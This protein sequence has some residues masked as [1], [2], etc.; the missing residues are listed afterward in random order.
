MHRFALLVLSLV[1]LCGFAPAQTLA[2]CSPADTLVYFR[3]WSGD[4]MEALKK[5]MGG[6]GLWEQPVDIDQIFEMMDE[7]MSQMSDF[8]G[9]EGVN[10]GSMVRS[11]KGYEGALYRLDLLDGFPEVDFVFTLHT[12]MADKIYGLLSGK[13][14]EEAMAD[15]VSKDEVEVNVDEFSMNIGKYDDQIIIASSSNRLRETMKHFGSVKAGSLAQSERFKKAVGSSD[16]PDYCIYISAQPFL[17]ML[18]E[19]MDFGGQRMGMMEEAIRSFGLFKIDALGWTERENYSHFALSAKSNIEVLEILDCGRG[20]HGSLDTMPS[21]T[22]IGMTWNGSTEALWQKGSAFA[23]D[24][25]KNPMAPYVEEGLRSAQ[26][27]MGLKIGEIAA[28]GKGGLSFGMMPN[29][30]GQ[31]DDDPSNFFFIVHTGGIETARDTV[32]KLATVLTKR[33]GGE[34]TIEEDGDAIWYHLARD[35]EDTDPPEV[36]SP[37]SFRVEFDLPS[38]VFTGNDIIIAVK[39][40]AQKVMAARSGAIPTLA[41]YN[42]CKG[43]PQQASAYVFVSL[44]TILGSVGNFAAAYHNMRDGAGIAAAI[45]IQPNRFAVRTSRPVSQIWG[46]MG[47]AAMA[48]EGQKKGRRAI[49][50]DL[51]KIAKKYREYRGEHQKDPTTLA[52]LGFTGENALRYPPNRPANVPGKPYRLVKTEGANLASSRR[53]VVV[54]CPDPRYGRLVGTL[55]GKSSDWSEQRFQ[56]TFRRQAYPK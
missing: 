7:G 45:D 24:K 28:I 49:L 14:V 36:D 52:Q 43:L 20:G 30:D 37:R 1:L 23:L 17:Q 50:A 11:I 54:I 31:I 22:V 3:S 19:E 34:I 29:A 32:N 46:A 48:W 38:M 39:P 33:H 56:S 21:D 44:K 5:I 55:D 26:Q 8:I 27:A 40:A 53:V 6:G 4:P 15:E 16:V 2:H 35:E 47:G 9:I 10:I 13:L 41:Q 25:E 42:V 18:R 12:P 51:E